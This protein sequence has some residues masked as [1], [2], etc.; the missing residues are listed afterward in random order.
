MVPPG[1]PKEDVEIGLEAKQGSAAFVKYGDVHSLSIEEM[2]P[3][4][5]NFVPEEE[6]LRLYDMLS[7]YAD[8]I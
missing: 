3:I 4:S 1:V 7:T 6:K 8:C 2:F 5:S